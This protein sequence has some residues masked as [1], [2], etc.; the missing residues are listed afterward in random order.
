MEYD[1]EEEYGNTYEE[2]AEIVALSGYGQSGKDSVANILKKQGYKRLAFADKIRE[3]L[4]MLNP[5]VSYDGRVRE[6]VDELGWERAKLTHPE[7]RELLQRMGDVGRSLYGEDFWVD[8]TLSEV[9][10]S[11][12]YVISDC[13][14]PNE[15][16]AIKEIG[17]KIF[18]V[19]RP[20]YG[21][22]NSH[23]SE[24]AMDGYQFRGWIMNDGSLDDLQVEV[25]NLMG[26]FK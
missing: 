21:P 6:V 24:T 5:A 16:K 26:A 3:S 10:Y 19:E 14:Y 22:A 13:R 8:L 9:T 12:K 1:F 15:A 4:Y 23:H 2:P 7:V 11:E 17:G 18:R 20:G 25:D